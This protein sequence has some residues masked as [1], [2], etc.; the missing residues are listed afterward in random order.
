MD[1]DHT[2]FVSH[3]HISKDY[4]YDFSSLLECVALK[5]EADVGSGKGCLVSSFTMKNTCFGDCG[6]H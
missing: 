2:L 6:C 1:H 5:S 3:L 4:F